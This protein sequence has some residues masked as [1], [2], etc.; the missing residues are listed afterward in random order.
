MY[1]HS[2]FS[3]STWK[4]QQMP[5]YCAKQTFL[6]ERNKPSWSNVILV[7]RYSLGPRL[8]LALGR[9]TSRRGWLLVD[10]LLLGSRLLRAAPSP[11]GCPAR[12]PSSLALLI[13]AQRRRLQSCMPVKI[14]PNVL[15]FLINFLNF[16]LWRVESGYCKTCI[17]INR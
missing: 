8:L 11:V 4:R 2:L 10:R 15:F 9:S 13:A 12:W 3:D 14:Y 6:V 17:L 16:L 5:I 1:F 7:Y